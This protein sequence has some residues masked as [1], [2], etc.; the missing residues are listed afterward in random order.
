MNI[1]PR[2]YKYRSLRTNKDRNHTLRI[3]THNEIYFAKCTEFNDPFDCHLHISV[4][5]DFNTHKDRLRKLNPDLSE[6]KLDMQTQKDL[7]PETIKKREQEIN[8]YIHRRN[9]HAGIFR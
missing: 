2:L 3:L 1:P 8:N 6:A 9:E 7:K 5:G 4:E